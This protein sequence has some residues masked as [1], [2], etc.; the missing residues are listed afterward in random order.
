MS[1]ARGDGEPCTSSTSWT[2]WRPGG[3]AC[4]AEGLNPWT[5]P[6]ATR[7]EFP[8]REERVRAAEPRKRPPRGRL[9]GKPFDRRVRPTRWLTF[10]SQ[11]E[12]WVNRAQ[13]AH[14]NPDYRLDVQVPADF[15]AWSEVEPCPNSHSSH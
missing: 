2:K 7:A 12:G 5:V 14:A 13:Q 11:V 10:Y 4:A 8:L 6:P 9:P 1:A 3:R 15:P